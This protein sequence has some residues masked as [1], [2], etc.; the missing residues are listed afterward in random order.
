MEEDHD[1]KKTTRASQLR[2]EK[3]AHDATDEGQA[4]APLVRNRKFESTSLHRRVC[5]PSVPLE[6][7]ASVRHT[8]AGSLRLAPGCSIG[9]E[10]GLS[11]RPCLREFSRATRC[12][13]VRPP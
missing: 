7:L 8:G 13:W 2:A 6:T 9:A 5:K 11:E 3:K 10:R 12:D 4:I 1:G